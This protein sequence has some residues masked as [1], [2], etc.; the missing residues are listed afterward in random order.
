MNLTSN[1]EIISEI[2]EEIYHG[3]KKEKVERRSN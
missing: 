2:Y 1:D 3:S